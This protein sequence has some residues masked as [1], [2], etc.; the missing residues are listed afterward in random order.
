MSLLY[1]VKNSVGIITLNRPEAMNAI[2]PETLREL[3]ECWLDISQDANLRCVILTAA[4]SRAFCTGSD[5][6]KTMPPPEGIAELTFGAETTPHLL[7]GMELVKIPILCA[8]NGYAVG[9]GLE[10]ALAC[11]LRIASR[12]AKFGLPE[13]RIGSIPGG[14]GTQRLPRIIGLSNAMHMLLTGAVVEAEEAH[15]IGLISHLVESD[16]LMEE[17]IVIADAI[18]GNA[19]LSVRAIKQLVNDGLEMPLD[20]AIAHEA[21]VFGILRDSH[22]RIEGRKAFQEKRKPVFEGR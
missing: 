11:D 1:Q 15:R 16:A 14:A 10:L 22:D 12:N 13:V 19:P 2:D 18:A 20:Q 5:L 8:I 21:F 3:R 6:K 4:G 7:D 17:A 9:G